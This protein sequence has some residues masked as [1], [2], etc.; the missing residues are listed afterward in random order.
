MSQTPLSVEVAVVEC[1]DAQ[2]V[3]AQQTYRRTRGF[4]VGGVI[5]VGV[6]MGCLTYFLHQ[7]LLQP[8]PAAALANHYA[9]GFVRDNGRELADRL[10][11]EVP[12]AIRQL[13][14]LAIEQMPAARRQFETRTLAMVRQQLQELAP[15]VATMV[16]DFLVSRQDQIKELL[17]VG[18]DPALVAQL[19]AQLEADFHQLLRT[20]DSRGISAL[21]C[22]NDSL[23]A[24]QLVQARLH[25]LATAA[26]L[27]PQERELRR[28]IA[29]LL[30]ALEERD[31]V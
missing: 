11:T 29:V 23:A 14:D 5:F 16:D 30:A 20:K 22:L 21:D 2:L 17:R 4:F 27:T 28:A 25:R 9:A 7:N 13:P 8:K 31:R 24:V 6:Y 10:V 12:A 18:Q 26:D 19:G 1:V 15:H 3:K